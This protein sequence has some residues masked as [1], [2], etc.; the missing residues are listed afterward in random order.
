MFQKYFGGAQFMVLFRNKYSNYHYV[1][2]I[3]IKSEVVEIFEAKRVKIL[4]TNNGIEHCNKKVHDIL[5][6]RKIIHQQS[7]PHTLEQN[8]HAERNMPNKMMNLL[9]EVKSPED[10]LHLLLT[11]YV[12]TER[13]NRRL[14]QDLKT[15]EKQL[16]AVR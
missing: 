14:G 1:Y 9:E 5:Q 6:Q 12:E 16:E 10:K 3:P 15:H 4:R 8:E 11:K 2:C 13:Q 7:T